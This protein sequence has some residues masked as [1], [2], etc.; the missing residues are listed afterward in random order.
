MMK[1]LRTSSKF[2]FSWVW[3]LKKKSGP[4]IEEHKAF[5]KTIF[6]NFQN[7][8]QTFS[9]LFITVILNLP[10]SEVTF[11][12]EICTCN[13]LLLQEPC[14]ETCSLTIS[15]N[16]TTYPWLQYGIVDL[17]QIR[18]RIKFII[19]SGSRKINMDPTGSV[20]IILLNY[21]FAED[22]MVCKWNG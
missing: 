21:L 9:R 13:A 10:W 8:L 15:R 3:P 12:T 22:H 16:I 6:N 19:E 17:F 7:Q 5:L 14:S 20:T 2:N 4:L 18:I 1:I 11:Q